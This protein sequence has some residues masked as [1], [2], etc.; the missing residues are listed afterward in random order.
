[1]ALN[2][3]SSLAYC[4]QKEKP[5]RKLSIDQR[6]KS[7]PSRRGYEPQAKPHRAFY[8][9]FC[10]YASTPESDTT[11]KM[12]GP[13]QGSVDHFS[14]NSWFGPKRLESFRPIA[15]ACLLPGPATGPAG[16]VDPAISY[17]PLLQWG[18]SLSDG[19][20]ALLQ[21]LLSLWQPLIG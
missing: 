14:G 8:L 21:V 3:V 6:N 13:Q 1:M 9:R 7:I 17:Q 15:S 4:A 11:N 5:G 18:P 20:R 16:L 10:S 12:T 19:S 2:C